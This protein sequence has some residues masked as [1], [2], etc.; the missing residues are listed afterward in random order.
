VTA[1][2][3]ASI[4]RATL[5][6]V[7]PLVQE[8]LE[9]WLL[10]L[11]AGTVGRAASAVPLRHAPAAP[12]MRA[13]IEDRYRSHGLAPRF[14]LA[15]VA[16]FDGL[17]SDLRDSGY[18]PRDTTRVQAG[19]VA[20]LVA[21]PV[22][23]VDVDIG[24]TPDDRWSELFLGG[25]FDAVDAASRL[26]ILRRAQHSLFA[27]ACIDGRVVAV[28]S[29][30][31]SQ[32]WCGLHAMRTA[33]AARGQGLARALLAA[34]GREAAARGYERAMLQVEAGNEPALSLYRR[35]GFA[36]AWSY[37]YWRH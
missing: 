11:D 31:L 6:A 15:Q 18:G 12:G 20:G 35:A 33:P 36:D 24:P 27:S 9:G 3:I 17:R 4:E 19:S 37:E 23:Q 5:A 10:G 7:P 8:E 22:P 25:G 16:A 1:D 21:L 13:R 34:L 30:C 32:G 28:G 14:R 26:G 29:A 2:D